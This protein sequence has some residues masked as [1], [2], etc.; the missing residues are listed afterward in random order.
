MADIIKN[1]REVLRITRD[2][3]RGHDMVN[4]R[5]FYSAGDD[6][7]KPGRQGVAFRAA[8]LPEV[9]DALNQLNGEGVA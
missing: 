9:L 5:V 6:D 8:L 7:M 2:D 3:F 1:S 4:V